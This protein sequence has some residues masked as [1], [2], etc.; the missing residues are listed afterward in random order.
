MGNWKLP[1]VV[2][3]RIRPCDVVEWLSDGAKSLAFIGLLLCAMGIALLAG[4][5]VG[6][7]IVISLL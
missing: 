6:L 7:K 4:F 3:R 1:K 2:G 5:D